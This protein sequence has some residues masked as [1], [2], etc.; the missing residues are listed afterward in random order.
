M[1]RGRLRWLMKLPESEW[2][3]VFGTSYGVSYFVCILK[4]AGMICLKSFN[5]SSVSFFRRLETGRFGGALLGHRWEHTVSDQRP[6][7]DEE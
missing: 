6:E 4:Y 5:V 7:V 2:S 1:F 3:G